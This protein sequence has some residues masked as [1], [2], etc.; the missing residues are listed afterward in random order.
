MVLVEAAWD[1]ATPNRPAAQFVEVAAFR[2]KHIPRLEREPGY[3]AWRNR[4]CLDYLEIE[5]PVLN[6]R[7]PQIRQLQRFTIHNFALRQS[8]LHG[9][10]FGQRDEIPT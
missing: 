2:K 9:G 10:D 1:L 7:H 5:M 6:I 4:D 8:R 3:I